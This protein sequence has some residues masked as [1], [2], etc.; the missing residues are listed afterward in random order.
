[1]DRRRTCGPG[2]PRLLAL[3]AVLFGLFLM[4]GA[5]VN[6][7]GG[8]HGEGVMPAP[9]SMP[10]H[11]GHA[12]AQG[13][14]AGV[15]AVSLTTATTATTAMTAMSGELCVSTPARDR[16]PLPATG[17]LAGLGL[18]GLVVWGLAGRPSAMWG[19]ARRGPP[20]GGRDFLLQ[21]CVART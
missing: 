3:C 15:P 6:A 21:V 2:A 16:L 20:S 17:L 9:V 13:E 18:V 11:S 19:P 12:A 8:C 1:M 4:H 14:Q 5:P 10:A 7:V